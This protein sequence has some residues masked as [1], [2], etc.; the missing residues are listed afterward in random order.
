MV[1][2][3][4]NEQ[5]VGAQQPADLGA[6]PLHIDAVF[7]GRNRGNGG[8]LT[9]LEAALVQVADMPLNTLER[10]LPTHGRIKINAVQVYKAQGRQAREYLAILAAQVEYGVL[11]PARLGEL[12]DG[13]KHVPR[14]DGIRQEGCPR[15]PQSSQH[16]DWQ[17]QPPPVAFGK[18]ETPTSKFQ[19][20][21]V[22]RFN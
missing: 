7:N 11:R 15:K 12:L 1:V 18:V 20:R 21:L 4:E 3:G 17:H 13:E 5:A 14:F 16:P 19:P 9:R 2:G 22:G 6:Q 8:E 10:R